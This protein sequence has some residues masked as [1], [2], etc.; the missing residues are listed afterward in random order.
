MTAFDIDEEGKAEG[1]AEGEEKGELKNSIVVVCYTNA[2][3]KLHY[4]SFWKYLSMLISQFRM[5]QFVMLVSITLSERD[6]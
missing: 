5:L 4:Q 2:H 1:L 6:G 3:Y